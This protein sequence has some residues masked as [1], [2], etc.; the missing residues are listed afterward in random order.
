MKII[1]A[2]CGMGNEENEIMKRSNENENN[3]A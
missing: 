2:K 1:M 3:E